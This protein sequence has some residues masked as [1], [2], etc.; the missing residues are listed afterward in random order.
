MS[1][2]STLMTEAGRVAVANA[3]A[4]G[5]QVNI[6]SMAVGD[7]NGVEY[8]PD[9]NQIQLV[10]ERYSSN[11]IDVTVEAGGVLAVEMVI[12]ADVGGWHIREA[13]IKDNNGV[14]LALIRYPTTY[15]PAPQ[16]NI[17]SIQAITMKL[18]FANNGPVS[19]QIDEVFKQHI[20]RQL[21]PDFR[22]VESIEDNPPE[23]ASAGQTW[24][25]GLEPTDDWVGHENELAEWTGTGW[26][27]AEPTPWMFVGLANRSDLRWDHDANPPKWRNFRA[28]DP[29]DAADTRSLI[30][31]ADIAE[32]FARLVETNDGLT[33]WMYLS[34]A[35]QPVQNVA[36]GVM[37]PSIR[38]V[39]T[40]GNISAAA[41]NGSI[42]RFTCQ[43]GQGGLYLAYS[44]T[45]LLGEEGEGKQITRNGV[46]WTGT[47]LASQT[48]SSNVTALCVPV[49][50]QPG[51]FIDFR[52]RHNT[53]IT[54]E[55]ANC[56]A[57]VVGLSVKE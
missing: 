50:M 11:N 32:I 47:A 42:G 12:P 15:K 45:N 38:M 43:P 37:T 8:D 5:T 55:T 52:M 6:T 46:E 7:G 21:R 18:V 4:L 30:S 49:P 24:I 53:G 19:W 2:F 57:L 3:V 28:D 27:F 41:W 44:R 26:V 56:H 51:D 14:T 25:V 36:T 29:R 39:K 16:S 22:S 13:A 9:E 17:A 10:N 31:P 20:A 54:R 1:D 48:G 33:P 40:L 23:N 35:G 34:D